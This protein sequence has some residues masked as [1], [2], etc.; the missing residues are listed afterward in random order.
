V[1]FVSFVVKQFCTSIP[2]SKLDDYRS[3]KRLIALGEK[4][5]RLAHTSDTVIIISYHELARVDWQSHSCYD[6]QNEKA[7]R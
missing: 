3:V 4:R 5:G 1:L 7:R 2:K 6:K